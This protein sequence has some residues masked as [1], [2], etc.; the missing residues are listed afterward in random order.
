MS[1]RYRIKQFFNALKYQLTL[2]DV[3]FVRR[4]L[5]KKEQI[6]FFAMKKYDQQHSL[7]VAHKCLETA[8]NSSWI[9]ERL[10]VRAALLH[11]VGKSLKN[12]GLMSR[13]W[14]VFLTEAR[15]GK[16]LD[17]LQYEGSFFKFRRDL[18]ALKEH[19]RLGA[20][21]IKS[22]GKQELSDIIR[23]HHAKPQLGESKL[24]P[25]LRDIDSKN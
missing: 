1:K 11:D 18:S 21:L 3:D 12:V 20:E 24:L 16:L 15:E 17:K 23:Y 13:V 4:F 19:G 8:R 9:D 25:I 6:F 14:Y 5:D 2:S 10:L 7:R 22:E